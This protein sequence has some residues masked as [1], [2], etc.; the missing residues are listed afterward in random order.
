MTALQ[1]IL[2]ATVIA[3]VAVLAWCED[4]RARE[5]SDHTG[6]YCLSRED[7][8]RCGI[9]E[10]D[11]TVGDVDLSPSPF[12]NNSA[13]PGRECGEPSLQEA[14]SRQSVIGL[15]RGAGTEGGSHACGATSPAR[16]SREGCRHG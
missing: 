13:V 11:G 12:W 15:A 6:G 10:S 1:L 3:F 2:A 4:V 7:L 16:A 9:V 5:A 8:I 14:I